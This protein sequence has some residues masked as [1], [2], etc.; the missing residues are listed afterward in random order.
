MAII[1]RRKLTL[2]DAEKY[3]PQVEEWFRENPKRRICHFGD[4]AGGTWF[5]IRR[6]Y[7]REDILEHAERS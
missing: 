2:E 3:I 7:V 4:D 5:N 6:K 1:V